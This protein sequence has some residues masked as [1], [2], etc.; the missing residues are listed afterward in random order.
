[1]LGSTEEKTIELLERSV[2]QS[3][4][5]MSG[6]SGQGIVVVHGEDC[7]ITVSTSKLN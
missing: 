1:M 6:E 5:M 2:G 7:E 3:F 4:G